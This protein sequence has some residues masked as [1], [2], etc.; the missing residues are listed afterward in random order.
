VPFPEEIAGVAQR[1]EQL[2]ALEASIPADPAVPTHGAFRPEQVLVAGQGIGFIDFDSFCMAEPAFDIALFRAST[3]DN[4]L[5][6]EHIR[7]RDEAEIDARRTRIDALNECFLAAYEA[8]APVSHQRVALWEAIFYLNDSLQCW[9][10]PRPNDARL[11]V[12]L[13]ERH[14]RTLG[15]V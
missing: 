7:P 4:G 10:K 1:V 8:H 13:L 9:T 3:M 14:L 15:I 5:Y 12:Q 11:V 6:D 2:R